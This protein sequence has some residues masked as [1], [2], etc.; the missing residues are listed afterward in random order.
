ME[1]KGQ[2]ERADRPERIPHDGLRWTLRRPEAGPSPGEEREDYRV[3]LRC[4][5][6]EPRRA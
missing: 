1:R 5:R 2:P 6:D 4:L 3:V